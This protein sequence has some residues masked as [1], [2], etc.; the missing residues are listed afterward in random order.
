MTEQAY[1]IPALLTETIEGLN[2]NPDGIYID[3][4]FGGGGHSRSILGKLSNRGKL[5][6]FDQDIDAFNNQMSSTNNLLTDERIISVHANFR[7]MQRFLRYYAIK[8]VNGILAD[9][10]VSFHHFDTGERGFSF[11]YDEPLDMRMNRS[12]QIS[13]ADIVNSYDETRLSDLFYLYGELKQA[14]QIAKSICRMREQQPLLTTGQLVEATRDSLK[15]DREKKDLARVFQALRIEVNNE[16]DAL[17]DFLY[18]TSQALTTGGRLAVLTYHSLEDRI[19][20][21]FMR[22]GNVQGLVSKDFYGNIITPLKPLSN[23]AVT[24]TEQEIAANPRA[25]SAK[26]RIAIKTA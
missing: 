15:Y 3:A 14:R 22:T 17:R 6:V 25:R 24:A 4:T 19:V 1:H 5:M 11:R 2:I 26:L 18:Q 21:N 9:L 23:K 12:A 8:S 20:K 13:A 7:Y 10:G 16:M